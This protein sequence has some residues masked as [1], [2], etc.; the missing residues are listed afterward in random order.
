VT[1]TPTVTEW[2]TA[3]LAGR[4]NLRP[5]TRRLYD[6]HIRLYLLPHLG[7]LRLDRLRVTHLDAMFAAIE[8]HNTLIHTAHASTDPQIRASVKGQRPA[9]AATQQRIRGTLRKALNDAIRRSLI[10]TNPACHVELAGKRPKPLVWTDERVARWRRTG[11]VPGGVPPTFRTV[12]LI[13][14]GSE[15]RMGNAGTA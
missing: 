11:T 13:R 2:L 3:W 1:D 12:D 4:R 9:E 14:S 15:W 5:N 8:D 10:I 7:H 6:A